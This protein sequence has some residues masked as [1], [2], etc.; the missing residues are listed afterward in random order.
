LRECWKQ[1]TLSSC[2]AHLR[3]LCTVWWL[4][5][6]CR[7]RLIHLLAVRPYKKPE[8]YDRIMKG[9]VYTFSYTGATETV[10][11]YMKD[12]STHSFLLCCPPTHTFSSFM[13]K[14]VIPKLLHIVT[15][16]ELN[17]RFVTPTDAPMIHT[18]TVLHYSCIFRRL[19][20]HP[21]TAL[22]QD[23]KLTKL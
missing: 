6:F 11:I 18:F 5:L 12:E 19:L 10:L 9:T 23:L 15:P 14:S 13:H 21:Q 22:H 8:L 1:Q 3:V 2:L 20:R 7:E 16:L 4:L 17:C